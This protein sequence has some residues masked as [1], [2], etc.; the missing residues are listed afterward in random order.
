M[1]FLFLFSLLFNSV[2]V[3]GQEITFYDL[4]WREVGTAQ[5]A[6]YYK[7]VLRNNQNEI[8]GLTYY[9][10]SGQIKFEADENYYS[11]DSIIGKLKRWYANGQVQTDENRVKRKLTDTLKTY[12][13]N[14]AVKR[15]EIWKNGAFVKG[16]CFDTKGNLL[17]HTPYI[18][19][20]SFPQGKEALYTFLSKEI[21]YPKDYLRLGVEGEAKIQFTVLTD[22]S[23]ANF[24]LVEATNEDF[25]KEALRVMKRMPK[26]NIGYVDD[27]REPWE[28]I[29]PIQFKI[30]TESSR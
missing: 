13:E 14:G 10:V 20:P 18:I 29:L 22:G 16:E 24:H 6:T 11:K 21:K 19:E 3:F 28:Y 17:A 30:Q 8:I 25:G 15:V 27:K 12:Y 4:N 26:W 9:F 1:K 23:L 5:K 7:K 2:V